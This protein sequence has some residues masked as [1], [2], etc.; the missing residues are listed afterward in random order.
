MMKSVRDRT[1]KLFPPAR[2]PI[3]PT[4]APALE[5]SQAG[6]R[7]ETIY[8]GLIGGRF[9]SWPIT[10]PFTFCF[11]TSILLTIKNL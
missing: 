5:K 1:L 6:E 3:F 4:L 9:S 7:E 11:L 8:A 10:A 2:T